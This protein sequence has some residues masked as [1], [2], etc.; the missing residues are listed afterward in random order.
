VEIERGI[1]QIMHSNGVCDLR[2]VLAVR[3]ASQLTPQHR[4]DQKND[5]LAEDNS[6]FDVW[7]QVDERSASDDE[8]EGG[9]EGINKAL[10]K[11]RLKM[12]RSFELLLNTGHIV[13]FEVCWGRALRVYS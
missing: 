8:D 5:H 9:E 11:P 1:Y 3:R 13:R 7:A 12:K 6:W 10:D 4:H 2:N